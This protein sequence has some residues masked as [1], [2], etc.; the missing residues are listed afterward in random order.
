M[1]LKSCVCIFD[2]VNTGDAMI[3]WHAKQV[4][5]LSY[6]SNVIYQIISG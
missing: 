1:C 2:R 5:Q 4:G 6:K 3:H